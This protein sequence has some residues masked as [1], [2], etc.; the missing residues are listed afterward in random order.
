MSAGAQS[1]ESVSIGLE[2]KGTVLNYSADIGGGGGGCAATAIS[3]VL[4][5]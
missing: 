1:I 5:M 4:K 3:S 2:K